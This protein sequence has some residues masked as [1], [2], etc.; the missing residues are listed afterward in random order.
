MASL[1]VKVEEIKDKGEHR[2]TK[3]IQTPVL[4]TSTDLAVLIVHFSFI[5]HGPGIHIQQYLLFPFSNI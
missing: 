5:R 1:P 3:F 2:S 4:L